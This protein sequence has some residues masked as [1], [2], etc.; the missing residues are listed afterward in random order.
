MSRRHLAGLELED[1]G[2]A[3]GVVVYNRSNR[4]AAFGAHVIELDSGTTAA[5]DLT[6]YLGTGSITVRGAWADVSATT[7]ERSGTCGSGT[8]TTSVVKPTGGAN[9]T[10]DDFNGKW[11]K[12]VSSDGATTHYRVVLDTTTTAITIR[13]ASGVDETWTFSVVEPGSTI[14]AVTGADSSLPIV[15]E[16]VYFGLLDLDRMGKVTVKRCGF[17]TTQAAGTLDLDD[18]RAFNMEDCYFGSNGTA[19]LTDVTQTDIDRSVVDGAVTL[20]NCQNVAADFYSDGA[21]GTPLTIEYARRVRL[22]YQC[23]SAGATALVL[24]GIDNFAP[25]GTGVTGTSNTGYGIQFSDGGWYDITGVTLTGST[26]D[27][28]I[29]G[30]AYAY[31][32]L[33]RVDTNGTFVTTGSGTTFCPDTTRWTGVLTYDTQLNQSGRHLTYGYFHYAFTNSLT[34]YAGG[35]QGSATAL[36]VGYNRVTTVATANDSVILPSNAVVGGALVTVKN[37]GAESLDIF[38]QSGGS[39]NALGAN[40]A[41][42]LASGAVARFVSSSATTWD[43]W[44]P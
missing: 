20:S 29:E 34:A 16:N 17:D 15:F 11:L 36:G 33:G 31:S 28:E 24:K 9:W 38:P 22:A 23:S 25:E 13:A 35:G 21:S 42:A 5:L 26:N 1:L 2:A 41:Y 32:A 18:V 27:I 6:G 43:A 4:V 8:N 3:G 12:L 39:I 19:I 44:T 7:G 40:T 37:A 14:T 10:V 30:T